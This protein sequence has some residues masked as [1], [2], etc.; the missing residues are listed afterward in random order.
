MTITFVAP[1]LL[2]AQSLPTGDGYTWTLASRLG[3]M[4]YV[5][6]ELFGERDASFTILGVEFVD[7]GPRLWYPGNR[8][9]I[10][11]QL[12]P[13]AAVDM[14]Q[15]CYQ[16]AH[17]VVHLLAPV[18]DSNNFEEAVACY[19]SEF[20]MKSKFGQ[21]NWHPIVPSYVRA[22]ALVAPRLNNDVQCIR[23][24]RDKTPSFSLIEKVEF[25]KEFPDLRPTDVDFLLS[26]FDRN[27]A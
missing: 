11:I 26:K 13:S 18:V 4:L 23:R 21:N 17:E 2:V 10:V 20:Y 1:N 3:D 14:S 9:D 16:L 25:V 5:A 7:N 27:M 12:G 19:F 15:A 6:Q 22:L 8:N 24:L